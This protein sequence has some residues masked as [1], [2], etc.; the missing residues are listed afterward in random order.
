MNILIF[1]WRDIRHEWA[2]GGEV[3]IHEIAKRWVRSGNN[4]TLFCGQ[5]IT[6]TLP[7]EE[8]ID[9]IRVVR[10]GGRFS[11]YFWAAW[12]YFRRF[13][14]STDVIVDVQNGIPFFTVLYSRKPKVAVVYH[15]HGQQ[16]FI[17]LPF[18]YNIIGYLIERY[19][20]PL[21][22]RSVP[23]QVISKTTKSDVIE[24]G[25]NPKNIRVVYCGI[26]QLNNTQGIHQ[27]FSDPTVLY[28]GRIK[29]YKRVEMLVRIMPQLTKSVPNARL[30]IAGW[31]TD[32]STVT[33]ASMRSILR[34]RIKIIGPVTV[35]EKRRLL[36]KSW[37]FVNPSINEGWGISVIEANVYGTPAVA[38]NVPG[39][40]ESIQNGK[41]GLLA[42]T[43]QALTEH[44]TTLLT[45][46]Q[47]RRNMAK[48]AIHWSRQFNWDK[49]AKE[50]LQFLKQSIET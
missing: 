4:V 33:D 17:E 47:L 34:R 10:K 3:Y 1:N 41:T 16:F 29:K 24:R 26:D 45:N 49:A 5:D 9:G 6:P 37:V 43:E 19:I 50:S 14:G 2:G 32:A 39:L 7:D 44:I 46:H 12:Y 40:S 13:R 48:S 22:Y 42:D 38:F 25:I 31:G 27:K 11:V 30:L 35:K 20:F 23:I 36:Q 8:I 18:P 21:L 28:L 15:I